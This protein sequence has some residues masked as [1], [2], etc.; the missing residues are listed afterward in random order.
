MLTRGEIEAIA[1]ECGLERVAARIAEAALPAARLDYAR[2]GGSRLGGLPRL[3]DDVEWPVWRGRPMSPL[4]Q[5]ALDDLPAELSG[6]GLPETGA[7]AFFWDSGA[8]RMWTLHGGEEAPDAAGWGFD[9]ADAGAA[10]V[11]YAEGA[12]HPERAA[13]DGLPQAALL[14]ARSARLVPESTIP[15]YG[16]RAFEALDLSEDELDAYLDDFYP[17]VA[18]AEGVAGANG[19]DFAPRHQL[20]GHPD[21]IQGDMQ[22]EAQLVTNGLYCGDSTGYN[23]PRAR[24]LEA[25]AD[26]WR[27]LFQLGSDEEELGVMWGDVGRLYFWIR[28]G[29]LRARRFD[30]VWLILQCG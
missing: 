27:L 23:D 7:L 13:P 24:E 22:L 15:S 2:D 8:V 20:L 30:A 16:S 18:A 14:L 12:D 26:D 29:D 4:A 6:L 5:V 10:A 19:L 17:R 21:V 25:G 1:G 11:V 3:P 9:P 28:D